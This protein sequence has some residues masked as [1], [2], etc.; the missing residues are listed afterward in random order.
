MKLEDIREVI[1]SR[2]DVDVNFK[3]SKHE[4]MPYRWIFATLAKK[5]V[6]KNDSAIARY[7]DKNHS[8]VR[9]YLEHAQ[10][11]HMFLSTH[12]VIMSDVEQF[13]LAKFP[14]CAIKPSQSKTKIEIIA[15]YD[16]EIAKLKE[17]HTS[18][19]KRKD[20]TI[21]ELKRRLEEIRE[22]IK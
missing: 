3:T 1:L 13:L 18:I 4:F 14:G 6:T 5:Y 10:N 7:M 19:L 11:P 12:E 9:H 20:R 8:T 22:I 2:H 15:T 21:N 17:M 16:N